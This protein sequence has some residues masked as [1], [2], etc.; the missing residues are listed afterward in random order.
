VIV[1]RS[2]REIARIREAG[3]LVANVLAAV[4]A[5][6]TPGVR[7]VELDR[8]A[9]DMLAEAGAVSSF[10]RYHPR[11][12]PMPYPAVICLSL[13]EAIVHGIPDTRPLR[14]GDILSI[15]FGAAID[16]L[17]ADAAVTTGIGTV[18]ERDTRLIAATDRA[19]AA[20]IAAARP[21][22]RIG[23]ISAAIEAVAREGGYGVAEGL[24]GHGVGDAM[25]ED[26]SVPNR[27]VAGR[28]PQLQPGL[29]I[30][31]EPMFT[32]GGDEHHTLADGWT[33]VTSDRSR[34]AHAEHTIAIT[35]DGPEILTRS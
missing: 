35:P 28:G 21:G 32:R 6:A 5:A 8:L 25:H 29:V 4:R 19:L 10:L 18:D 12:A 17:H 13:N 7:P 20:G 14:S 22:G 26:P 15:D 31:I 2:A 23:D 34:A 11:W 33:I 9:A 1:L 3:R 24:G 16:G 30:A 27:G